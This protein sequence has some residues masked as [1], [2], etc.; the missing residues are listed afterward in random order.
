MHDA[1]VTE[2]AKKFRR[3]ATSIAFSGL[4][5]LG[6]MTELQAQEIVSN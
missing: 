6:Q 4:G 3:A 5:T 1:Q 2:I